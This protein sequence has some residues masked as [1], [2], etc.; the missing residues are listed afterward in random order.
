M[1]EIESEHNHRQPFSLAVRVSCM[2][3]LAAILPLLITV[4]TIEF[5]S[6]P[7]LINQASKEMETDA[8]TRTQLIDSYF[9]ERLLASETV[10]RLVPIQKFLA[11]DMSFEEKARES[12][13]SGHVR[14]SYYQDW[15]LFDVYGHLHMYY[16][17]PPQKHGAFYILPDALQQL[18]TSKRTL[19]SDVFYRSVTNEAS[20]DI[21]AP[22]VTTSYDVVGI[23]RTTF[24]LHSIWKIVDGEVGANG[25]GSYA[26][27]LDANGVRIAV[28]NPHPDP[29]AMTHS[30]LIFTST[31]PLSSTLQ[32]RIRDENLYGISQRQ[33]ISFFAEPDLST[34]QHEHTM[35]PTFQMVPAMQHEMFQVAQWRTYTVPWTY[36]VVSPLT[37]IGMVADQQLLITG[38]I[39]AFVLLLAIVS[40]VFVGR[41]FALP[42]MRSI[43]AQQLAYQNQQH[44]SQL[45][46]Q[47][48]LNVSHELR[49]PLTE[50][51]GYLELLSAYE[52][53]FDGVT[54]TKFLQNAM[55]GCEELTLLV[56]NVLGA[57]HIDDGTKPLHRKHVAVLQAVN[58]VLEQFDPRTVN[59]YI[60]QVHVAKTVHIEGDA[61]RLRQ[62]LRNLLSNAF[63][64]ASPQTQIII[65]AGY[66]ATMHPAGELAKEV[67]IC[68]SDQGPGIG[69]SERDLLFQKFTR[70]ERD[71]SGPVRGTGLGLYISKQLVEA[72][73]GRIWVESS[74][75]PGEGSRF[76]FTLPAST[77]EY[78]EKENAIQFASNTSYERK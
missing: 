78:A 9:A 74:G 8:Q 48:L 44:L 72:M 52:E 18:Q 61:Q 50:I 28:T 21:Y 69:R 4:I 45:K 51:Y 13:A 1:P 37:T 73:G 70:L 41:R 67:S 15:S 27:I 47:F 30:P 65:S 17:T 77:D 23:L 19:I 31:A 26:F 43:E 35:P 75:I 46:D 10:S 16:P 39:A 36:Y 14:G 20:I 24:D 71:L 3:V 54:K 40:G 59:N 49:T 42:L 57:I 32:Q 11:G 12:L 58:D 76:C 7:M 62:V 55:H 60:I 34:F 2:L 6:R 56:N 66:D 5:S 25:S 68:V 53:Q 33:S 29:E 64:Y 38:I 63:K 22:V